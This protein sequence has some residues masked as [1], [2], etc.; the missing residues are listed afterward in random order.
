MAWE[1]RMVTLDKLQELAAAA[2]TE[3]G[4]GLSE[5]DVALISLGVSASVTSLDRAAIEG[6]VARAFDGGATPAQVQ[7]ILSLVSGLG[8]H[9]LM[10]ASAPVVAC[11]RAAGF[12]IDETLSDEQTQLWEKYVGDDPFWVGFEQ[13]LPGFL[14]SMLLLSTD[15]FKAFFNYCAVPWKSGQV[16]AKIKELTAMACDATPAHRF[17]PGFRLHLANA[18]ALGAGR[19]ALD[20]VM[21]IAS[22]APVH[23]GTD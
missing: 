1:R 6:A 16:R 4:E 23:N 10:A 18:V 5:S 14:K 2:T 11:A 13:E 19:R 7:E 22:R 9:T 17:L 12:E 8:V 21:A 20:E 15:Q 3:I